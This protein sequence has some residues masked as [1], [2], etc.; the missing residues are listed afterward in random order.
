MRRRWA[1]SH[2][3]DDGRGVRAA[4][5]WFAS[6]PGASAFAPIELAIPEASQDP[7]QA[8]EFLDAGTGV[9]P[10]AIRSLPTVTWLDSR[11]WLLDR[12]RS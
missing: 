12:L 11:K 7:E 2:A 10:P 8:L 3:G 4:A 9:S 5:A 6:S 1:G